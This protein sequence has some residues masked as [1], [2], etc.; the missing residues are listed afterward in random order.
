MRRIYYNAIFEK[1]FQLYGEREGYMNNLELYERFLDL[2]IT[3][4]LVLFGAGE[5]GRNILA[6]NFKN[7]EVLYFCDND[8]NKWNTEIL[9]YKVVGTE[10][11]IKDKDKI[12]IL[13]S[14]GNEAEVRKQLE[15]LGLK[16]VTF[17]CAI[18][19]Y[20]YLNGEAV[21]SEIEKLIDP[22][23]SQYTYLPNA[24]YKST[25]P[26]I[27]SNEN[28]IM[29]VY[30]MLGDDVSKEVYMQ[31]I[32]NR[33]Y[34]YKD[35]S[36]IMDICNGQYFRR[37]FFNYSDCEVLID[38]GVYDCGTIK[39]F[40]SQVNNKFE[41]IYGFEPDTI[42]YSKSLKIF[43]DS[44]IDKMKCTIN[45]YG[46]Y[47]T[48]SEIYFDA[49]GNGSSAVTE[50][51]YLKIKVVRLDDVIDKK[52]TFIKMDIEGSE[53]N[54][55]LGAKNIL[56]ND[57]PKLAISIYHKASDL[58]EIPLLIKRLV[59]EYKIFIRHNSINYSETVMYATI[60]SKV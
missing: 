53:I 9:G 55:L 56:M 6:R 12:V 39:D 34:D 25:I 48:E 14:L 26:F 3:R 15:E 4:K 30:D 43:N 8:Q 11:L 50:D 35:Y 49:L 59:P 18:L 22:V 19:R 33:K 27:N 13:I 36:N 24:E 31:V 37:D 1:R 46:L 16:D 32:R 29:K 23:I 20:K 21:Q 57:K 10:Q 2:M 47:D 40:V 54:A 51:S 42:C 60:D 17:S 44:N 58:W 41:Y 28:S 52:V 38:A 45:P 5:A 7:E